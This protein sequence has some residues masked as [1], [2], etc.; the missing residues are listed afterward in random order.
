[1]E[2]KLITLI[3]MHCI[4]VTVF[5]Q[6]GIGT[7]NPQAQLDIRSTNQATPTNTDGILVPKMDEFPI[8]NPTATQDGMMVYAT[9]NGTPIKG[10]YYW[11]DLANNWI[12]V[13][14]ATGLEALNEGN[15]IGWRLIGRTP[16]NYGSIG[17][18]SVDLSTSSFVSNVNGAT[19]DYS[20]AMGF[21]TVA[22]GEA[23]LA[24]GY[25]ASALGWNSIA[26]GEETTAGNNGAVAIGSYSDAEELGSVA[27]GNGPVSLAEGSF[28][29]GNGTRS[30]GESS[31]A[32]GNYVYAESFSEIVIGSYN[33]TYTPISAGA[34][35]SVDRLFVIGNG[36]DDSSRSNALTVLKNGNVGIDS[37]NPAVKLHV[38]GGTDA[39]IASTS[40]YVTIGDI[41]SRHMVLDDNEIMVK[42]ATNGDNKLYLNFEGDAVNVWNSLGIGLVYANPSVALDV[43][44]SI[45][46]TGTITDVSDLRLKE[47]F[48]AIEN[49]SE[50]LQ[51]I[52]G[53]TYNMIND[54]EKIREYGVVAQEVEK[55]F[56]E[57]VTVVDPE[58]GYLGVSY[59][60]LI[61]ILLEAIKEQQAIIETL[62]SK[63]EA[64]AIETAQQN[65][66]ITTLLQRMTVLEAANN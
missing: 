46:Y 39:N 40:G 33:L 18:N 32:I 52:T 51:Q 34:W 29:I 56:P 10:F 26:I 31:L 27:F 4:A 3:I 24:M 53:Y 54:E 22:S 38:T 6:V 25:G 50:R 8:T 64:Q 44:G 55:V 20:L 58:N 36:V 41:A 16:V 60:Q 57:L 1:M 66:T 21:N 9:G 12:R 49:A 63:I 43:V 19:G 62:N 14:T 28:A 15:G 47:N 17:L 48:Q 61:P 13:G 2:K 65:T 35:A 5:G 7:T 23:S 37:N 45:E 59:I 11:D 42:N 30:Y